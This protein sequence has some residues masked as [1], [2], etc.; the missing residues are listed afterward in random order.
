ML[1]EAENRVKIEGILSETN[2]N[3]G[4]FVKDGKTIENINGSITVLVNQTVNGEKQSLEIPVHCYSNKFTKTGKVNPSYESIERVMKEFTS[5]AAAGGEAGAD[6]VRIT[7]ARIKM[8]EFYG[9]NGLVSY[10]R[11]TASFIGKATGDFKPEATFSLEFAV[12]KMEYATDKDGVEIEPKRLEVTGIVPLYGGK[13]DVVKLVATN[14]NV[15]DAISNYWEKDQTFKA[16]GRLN[17]TSKTETVI[18][19]VDFGEPIE[20]TRTVNKSELTITGGSQTPLEG[21]FAFDLDEIIAAMR[22]RKAAL[23]TQKNSGA[24]TRKAPAPADSTSRLA[25]EDLG[26]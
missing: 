17:F 15:V 23:E 21:D 5:I 22:E 2:L 19:E 25:G 12:S 10:P 18:E 6:K 14:P 20:K 8:N 26:F 3:Y 13:V 4:S 7:G 1:R 24:K 11:I 16:N 9:Q